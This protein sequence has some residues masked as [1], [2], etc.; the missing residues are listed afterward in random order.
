MKPVK[1]ESFNVIYITLLLHFINTVS[2][3]LSPTKIKKPYFGEGREGGAKPSIYIDIDKILKHDF[4]KIYKCNFDLI[5]LTHLKGGEG[6]ARHIFE[7]S[8]V[9]CICI[10]ECGQSLTHS[11]NTTMAIL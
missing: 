7:E 4:S 6:G 8:A 5:S 11:L 10:K 2:E 3:A 1:L 9:L